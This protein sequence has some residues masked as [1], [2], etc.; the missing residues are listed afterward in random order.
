VTVATRSGT[1]AFHGNVFE[2]IRNYEFNAR[3]ANL[4]VRD[5]LKQNQF[6][7]TIGGPIIR[8]RLFFFVGEQSTIKRS[9]PADNQGFSMTPAMLQGDFS[10]IASTQCQTRAITL[11][12]PFVNN[13]IPTAQMDPIAMKIA[14]LLPTNQI[15][16]CGLVNYATGG[17]QRQYQIPAKVDYT[18]NQKAKHLRPL[19][20]V[21]QLHAAVLRFGKSAVYG[22]HNGSVEP[23]SVDGGG[24]HI[25]VQPNP[26]QQLPSHGE[27]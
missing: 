5:S 24:L 8:N 14:A 23:D 21:E 3:S 19:H 9:N 4:L 11:A 1:N 15:N 26:N 16:S 20:A 7:G 22:K 18:L 17:N 12:A 27:P 25:C 2:Y 13:K 6:G 10:V